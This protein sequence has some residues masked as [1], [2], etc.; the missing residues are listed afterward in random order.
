[1]LFT[2]MALHTLAHLL[3]KT[4]TAL[5]HPANNPRKVHCWETPVGDTP[6]R[7]PAHGMGLLLGGVFL[8]RR[9]TE[10]CAICLL[11]SPPHRLFW[12]LVATWLLGGLP[13]SQAARAA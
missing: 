4:S 5:L 11:P 9:T 2:V 6:G 3:W 13:T 7:S 8:V 12:E 10:A 1:M